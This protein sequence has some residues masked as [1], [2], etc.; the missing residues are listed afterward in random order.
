MMLATNAGLAMWLLCAVPIFCAERSKQM[1][2]YVL[3][4]VL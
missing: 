3:L 1:A 4:V 2:S